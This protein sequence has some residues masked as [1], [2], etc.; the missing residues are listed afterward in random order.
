MPTSI[1]SGGLLAFVGQSNTPSFDYV[2]MNTKTYGIAQRAL[3]GRSVETYF[4]PPSGDGYLYTLELLVEQVALYPS[5]KIGIMLVN[6]ESDAQDATWAAAFAAN[7]GS[8]QVA[9]ETAIGRQVQ[10]FDWYLDPAQTAATHRATV[11]TQKDTWHAT[12]AGR[13]TTGDPAA[14]AGAVSGDNLHYDSPRKEAMAAVGM[15]WFEALP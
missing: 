15:T 3:I 2:G 9:I 5:A 7:I 4:E 12:I 13:I 8:F 14:Q 1:R 6:G 11:N 10:W